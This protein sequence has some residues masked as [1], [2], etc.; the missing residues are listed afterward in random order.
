MSSHIPLPTK[1]IVWERDCG[2][3]SSTGHCW[4]CGESVSIQ[5]CVCQRLGLLQ[6][7]TY[8]VC[9]YGHILARAHG[10]SVEPDN[11]R[12]IC[13]KCNLRMGTRNLNSYHPPMDTGDESVPVFL[14]VDGPDD[15]CEGVTRS[16]NRC[17]NKHSLGSRFCSTHRGQ[18]FAE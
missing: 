2:I 6:N 16:G 8:P 13:A 14:L 18:V 11:L 3:S 17:K 15:S 10:G 4:C 5:G 1:V 9:H 7:D 12:I